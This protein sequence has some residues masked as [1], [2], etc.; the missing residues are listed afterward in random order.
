[1]ITREN[2]EDVISNITPY[3]LKRIKN[4]EKEYVVLNLNIFNTG[5]TVDVCL[6]NN[7]YNNK[8]VTRANKN[9]GAIFQTEE[10]LKLIK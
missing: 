5:F 4:S 7:L 10:V 1:M 2:L 6:T 9:G 3:D 8:E